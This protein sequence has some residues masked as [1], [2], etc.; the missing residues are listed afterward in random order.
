MNEEA[1]NKLWREHVVL[2]T[3]AG[4]VGGATAVMGLGYLF[5]KNNPSALERIVVGKVISA[6]DLAL[7]YDAKKNI[8]LALPE[9]NVSLDNID[10]QYMLST[11]ANGANEKKP[12]IAVT[13]AESVIQGVRKVDKS[14]LV[15]AKEQMR[16]KLVEE[17]LAMPDL[18]SRLRAIREVVRP[19]VELNM[20]INKQLEQCLMDDGWL[21]AAV[22]DANPLTLTLTGGGSSIP[23]TSV[24]TSLLI[25][26]L[27]CF[28]GSMSELVHVLD[29][30]RD[31]SSLVNE[32]L[33]DSGVDQEGKEM[34]HQALVLAYERF[35]ALDEGM[36]EFVLTSALEKAIDGVLATPSAQTLYRRAIENELLSPLTRD[37]RI[38]K[39]I[40]DE[41]RTVFLA[42]PSYLQARILLTAVRFE[43][44]KSEDTASVGNTP[45]IVGALVAQGGVV[46]AKLAQVLAEDPNIDPT[47]RKV[48]GTMRDENEAM[49][50]AVFWGSIPRPVRSRIARLGQRLGTGSVKQVYRCEFSD[51]K[52]CDWGMC[53]VAV[54]RQHVEEEA[55]A[56][57]EALSFSNELAPV[58]KRLGRLVYGEFSLFAEGEALIE[59]ATTSIS[60][61]RFKVVDVLH[62]SSKVLVEQMAIGEGLTKA[63]DSNIKSVEEM[64]ATKKL[65]AKYH[66]A[67]LDAFLV[68]G[69]IHSDIHLGNAVQSEDVNGEPG[70]II[71]DIGQFVTIDGASRLALLWTLCSISNV[72]RRTTLRAIAL[73]HLGR[74][75]CLTPAVEE[76]YNTPKELR[77]RLENAYEEAIQPMENGELPSQRTAYI[78]FLRAA[79]KQHISLPRGAFP[80]A[81]L[82][83]GIISQQEDLDLELVFD[84]KIESFLRRNITWFEYASVGWKS[85]RY[86]I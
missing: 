47:Y 12:P 34:L 58:A 59:F 20:L 14:F 40:I 35:R 82:I 72:E 36:Q 17:A 32:T 76:S 75:S 65:L 4:I 28:P 6:F 74:V 80:V 54:L 70:F 71:F 27:S 38:G 44:A 43:N 73:N 69:L 85:L 3:V 62:N 86:L 10:I 15:L 78:M 66:N 2:C 19:S 29:G 56:S 7:S 1:I 46:A 50:A 39:Y 24:T 64:S 45:E 18:S 60:T 26:A 13:W 33:E 67:V 8:Y 61:G 57:L 84:L 52:G 48:L 83:D 51:E 5:F 31:V 53:A 11:S 55:L 41:V 77:R 16:Q 9:P 25:M 21:D 63:L 81:K 79:E 49:P 30:Q 42:L 37:A 23:V 22:L 68:S